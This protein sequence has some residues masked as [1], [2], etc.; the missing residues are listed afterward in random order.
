MKETIKI[1]ASLIAMTLGIIMFLTLDHTG[2]L[3]TALI[4]ITIMLNGKHLYKKNKVQDSINSIIVLIGFL[5]LV[6]ELSSFTN[7]IYYSDTIYEKAKGLVV[8]ILII[9]TICFPVYRIYISYK[10]LE[11]KN[12]KLEE[13]IR[14]LSKKK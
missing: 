5:L 9:Y 8:Y 12:R 11:E 13:E 4:S 7:T 2:I 6:I 10:E 14:K 1:L 3:L